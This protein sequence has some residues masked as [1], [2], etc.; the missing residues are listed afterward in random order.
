MIGARRPG[1]RQAGGHHVTGHRFHQRVSPSGV[2]AGVPAVARLP[3]SGADNSTLMA[4]SNA[5]AMI[6]RSLMR[7]PSCATVFSRRAAALTTPH[8]ICPLGSAAPCPAMGKPSGRSSTNPLTTC[9]CL[10]PFFLR[11]FQAQLLIRGG[12]I[13]QGVQ[14]HRRLCHPRAHAMDRGQ[15]ITASPM[16]KKGG[17]GVKSPAS[18]PFG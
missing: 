9:S 5:S 18:N 3:A 17:N 15:F 8:A 1:L 13:E 10:D 16:L 11:P 6:L 12:K 7:C 14:A 2:Y 4:T